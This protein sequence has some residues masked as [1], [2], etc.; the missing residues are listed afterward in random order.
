MAIKCT[1]C[2]A[3]IQDDSKFCK[4]CGAKIEENIQRIEIKIDDTADIKRTEYEEQESKLRQKQMKLDL[5]R[6]KR[7]P[8]ITAAKILCIILPLAGVFIFLYTEHF[9]LSMFCLLAF[10]VNVLIWK[11]IA[12]SNSRRRR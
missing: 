7:R 8:Y 3:S 9:I 1:E 2:G 12:E 4:Y 10:A 11:L 5:H 6:D